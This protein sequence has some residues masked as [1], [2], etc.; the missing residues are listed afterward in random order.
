MVYKALLWTDVFWISYIKWCKFYNN[1]LPVVLGNIKRSTLKLVNPEYEDWAFQRTDSLSIHFLVYFSEMSSYFLMNTNKRKVRKCLKC[2]KEFSRRF[3]LTNGEYFVNFP[4][5][6][7]NNC[8]GYTFWK[9][10][11]SSFSIFHTKIFY[12]SK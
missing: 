11:L 6:F 10:A 3:D 2:I 8:Q 7:C 9:I 1:N 4:R 12:M 5:D